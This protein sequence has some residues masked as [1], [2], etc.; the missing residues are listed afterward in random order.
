MGVDTILLVGVTT[1]G[2]VRASAVDG[3]SYGYRVII[4][5]EAVADRAVESH[6]MS[7]L[8]LDAKYADVSSCVEVER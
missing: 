1:S 4:D 7:L 2:C 6:L 8:D 3:C 5:R